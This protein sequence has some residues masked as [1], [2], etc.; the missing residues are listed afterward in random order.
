MKLHHI[1]F[2][3]KDIEKYENNMLFEA[4]INE[5]EDT[6]QNSKLSLYKNY[7]NSYIEL[8]QPLNDSAFTY[9]FLQKN[10]D[11][12]HHLCYEVNTE[13]E[14]IEITK[15]LRL[16]KVLGPVPALL[17]DNRHVYF[18]YSR[19]KNIVEFIV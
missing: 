7:T 1:G 3:V 19:N 9:N 4:K 12:F 2:V 10:G 18:Y 8:I 17:F 14:I 13:Q 15:N 16:I 6:I 11:G 5:I